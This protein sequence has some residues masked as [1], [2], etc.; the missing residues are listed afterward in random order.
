[1]LSDIFALFEDQ[2]SIQILTFA[3]GE[4]WHGVADQPDQAQ[5][6][7]RLHVCGSQWRGSDPSHRQ[8]CHRR[9]DTEI[10]CICICI[11]ICICMCIR[12]SICMYANTNTNTH[13]C[14]SIYDDLVAWGRKDLTS[15]PRVDSTS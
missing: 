7:L 2:G 10:G 5:R 12:I 4:R 9:W 15:P 8:S 11:C 13:I 6:P 1:M 14:I 3:G